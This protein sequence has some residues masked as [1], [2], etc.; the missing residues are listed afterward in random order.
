[1]PGWEPPPSGRAP[2]GGG[3]APPSSPPL[4]GPPSGVRGPSSSPPPTGPPTQ[5]IA[6]LRATPQTA[7]PR[8]GSF[9]P[10]DPTSW[11]DPTWGAPGWGDPEAPTG[12]PPAKA[13]N[14]RARFV[15]E[16]VEI[17]GRPRAV[18]R[19]VPGPPRLG[20]RRYAVVYDVDG[21]RIRLGILWFVLLMGSISWSPYAT[22]VLLAGMSAVAGKQAADAWNERGTGANW[23]A[24]ALLA[25]A[26]PLSAIF[27]VALLGI[28]ALMVPVVALVVAGLDNARRTPIA[29]AA[30]TTVQAALF[31][32]MAAAGVVLTYRFEIGA[33]VVL[34]LLVS[35][36]EVGDYIIGSGSSNS[37]EGPVAGMVGIVVVTFVLQVISVPPWRGTDIWAWGA[38]AAVCCPLG[39]LAASAVLPAA[40]AR[41]GALRRLDSLLLLA[42]VWAWTVGLY[43]DRL[44]QG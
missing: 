18:S 26:I 3:S 43:V 2:S 27:G 24:A 33:V 15:E 17:K 12:P 44:A 32:G 4:G 21:P 22:A 19:P 31:A 16:T 35:V 39:Q 42:P 6:P 29:E 36:Y 5:A 34:V 8:T 38:L 41:A 23:T 13:R 28:V 30:G 37:V 25:G 20:K 40:D 9:R 10:A 1:M 7:G 11:A 14:K